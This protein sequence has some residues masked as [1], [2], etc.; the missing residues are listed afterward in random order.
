MR[1][2]DLSW[3]SISSNCMYKK[4]YQ[5]QTYNLPRDVWWY[6]RW[7]GDCTKKLSF[8]LLM[9]LRNLCWLQANQVTAQ[10]TASPLV[11][12]M[13]M[14]I[15]GIRDADLHRL[16]AYKNCHASGWWYGWCRSVLTVRLGC[17]PIRWLQSET[18]TL[19]VDDTRYLFWL[20]I[21]IIYSKQKAQR[22]WLMICVM[23][24]CV[25][26]YKSI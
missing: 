7:S 23:P 14:P 11:V 10:G 5:K 17:T 18:A 3:L 16:S 4:K 22:D 26:C 12:G 19:L 2:A 15:C 9:T 25:G 21:V 13:P 8:Q 6:A 20:E 24:S 1:N